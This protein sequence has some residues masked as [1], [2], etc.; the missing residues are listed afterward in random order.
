MTKEQLE[1][2]SQSSSRTTNW[3]ADDPTD[4][5]I[6]H[7]DDVERFTTYFGLIGT[8]ANL[9]THNVSATLWAN[10]NLSINSSCGTTS[11]W[12]ASSHTSLRALGSVPITC[13]RCN[14]NQ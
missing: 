4:R 12:N 11:R 3:I 13:K 10:G 6:G 14:P 5:E 2:I 7:W 1:A 8:A 9:K